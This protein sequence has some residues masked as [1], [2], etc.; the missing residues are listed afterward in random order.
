MPHCGVAD[1]RARVRA[2]VG[3]EMQRRDVA[4]SCAGRFRLA[5]AA[6]ALPGVDLAYPVEANAVF[7]ALPAAAIARLHERYH[8]YV[9]DDDAGVVRLMCSWQTTPEDVDQ[10]ADALRAAVVR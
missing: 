3:A 2:I 10:L 6:A 1:D 7:L 8:F 4:S 5:A 9:W